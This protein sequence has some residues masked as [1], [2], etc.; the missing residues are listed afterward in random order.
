MQ[1]LRTA[2][3]GTWGSNDGLLDDYDMMSTHSDS[4]VR[5]LP[6]SSRYNREPS[7]DR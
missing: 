6:A 7:Y 1:S 5:T 4:R 3:G 2:P